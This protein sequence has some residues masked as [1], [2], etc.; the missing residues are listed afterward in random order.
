MQR[1]WDHSRDE[2]YEE[3]GCVLMEMFE[4]YEFNTPERLTFLCSAM[5]TTFYGLMNAHV[6]DGD[7][8]LLF[9][10]CFKAVQEKVHDDLETRYEFEKVVRQYES[11]N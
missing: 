6:S 7:I 9:D 2:D 8:C 5:S 4:D 1:I 3:A 10:D 11:S